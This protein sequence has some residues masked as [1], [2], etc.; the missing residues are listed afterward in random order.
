MN[1]YLNAFVKLIEHF[2]L[3]G[4]YKSMCNVP[5]Y[6]VFQLALACYIV[7]TARVNSFNNL[8]LILNRLP[9]LQNTQLI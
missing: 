3:Q 7:L 9:I 8:N 4:E 5:V 1:L 2:Y 6:P